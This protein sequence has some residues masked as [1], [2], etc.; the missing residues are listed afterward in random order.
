MGRLPD[1]ID[2][3]VK[4]IIRNTRRAGKIDKQPQ[5]ENIDEYPREALREA[6][7]NA[8]A[9]RD[10]SLIGAQTL[11]YVFDDRLEIRSPGTL[12][13]SVT[14]E[15]IRAHYS[16]PRNETIARA[17]LNLRYVNTLGSGVPR[18]I[19]L[20]KEHS[21]REPDFEPSSAQFMV[22]FWARDLSF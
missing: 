9:H 19:A 4:F 12:P 22:R 11:L 7:V 10:Y 17:L 13:N 16:R 8:V 15:N 18:M 2:E 3:T 6:V 20:L 5:Q 14:L 1:Q 21:K